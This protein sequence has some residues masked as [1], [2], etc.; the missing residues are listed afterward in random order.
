M[1][2]SPSEVPPPG[3]VIAA[4]S[5]PH[6][7][8]R[9]AVAPLAHRDGGAVAEL[10]LDVELVHQPAAAGEPETQAA[11]R[12]VSLLER[13]LD[14]GDPRSLVARDHDDRDPVVVHVAPDL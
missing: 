10:R 11:P 8:E 5:L 14:V 4:A 7:L 12:R 2:A 1:R 9:V 13:A 3:S 6:D